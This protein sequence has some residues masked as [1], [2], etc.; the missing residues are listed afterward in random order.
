M[1]KL[2]SSASAGSH[3]TDGEL[4]FP[5]HSDDSDEPFRVCDALIETMTEVRSA[6]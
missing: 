6:N 1:T 3:P 5:D 2:A 4:Q